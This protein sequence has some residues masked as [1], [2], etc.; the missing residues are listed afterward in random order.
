[1][2]EK[3]SYDDLKNLFPRYEPH[4][5]VPAKAT[6]KGYPH[7][8]KP[9]FKPVRPDVSPAKFRRQSKAAHKKTHKSKVSYVCPGCNLPSTKL[10]WCADCRRWSVMA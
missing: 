10:G 1:M 3:M 4:K 2:A 8:H 7:K 5:F 6:K 9:T